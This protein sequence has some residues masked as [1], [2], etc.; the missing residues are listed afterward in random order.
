[1]SIANSTAQFTERMIPEEAHARTFWE[2]IARYR[3]AKDFVKGKRVL[4]IACGEG[5][6]TAALARAGA[7]SV[8]GVDISQD[9]CDRARYKYNID[10]RVGNAEAI[11]LPDESIDLIV[12]FETIEHLKSPERFIN[13]CAR[14]L[15]PGGMV[16]V[17]T[18]NR[19]VYSRNGYRN[20][21]HHIE[22]SE[23]E[24]VDLFLA[25]FRNTCLYTQF[26][27]S[28]AWWS[29][30]ALTAE[31]SPWLRIKGFWTLSCLLCPSIRSCVDRSLR[32][33][34]DQ[35]ILAR[36]PIWSSLFNPYQVRKQHKVN[37][38]Q[39]YILIITAEAVR[40]G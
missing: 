9:V 15:A 3:F 24:F 13:E 14:V 40:L 38:E 30:R 23:Q 34:A 8:V 31:E 26:P 22:F 19:L 28:V 33:S 16:I 36:E 32:A 7:A 20:P 39:P 5:Y 11:P 37:H 1:M 27:R 18:P 10:A 17:S 2:H 25:R 6:G 29:W 12:S 35:V 4:D 21:F